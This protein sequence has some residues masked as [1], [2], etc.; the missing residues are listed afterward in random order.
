VAWCPRRGHRAVLHVRVVERQTRQVQA[1]VARKGHE[2]SN[3]SSDTRNTRRI[4]L[5]RSMALHC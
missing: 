2:S 3:L 1:L 4:R 5:V